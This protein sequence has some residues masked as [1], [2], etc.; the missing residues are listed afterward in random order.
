MLNINWDCCPLVAQNPL[1]R[2]FIEQLAKE[3]KS[4]S[5][6][7]NYSRDLNDFLS[8]FSNTPF[9]DQRRAR[10]GRWAGL[11]S[12]AVSGGQ[13]LRRATLRK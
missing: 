7:E 6:I 4:A 12:A 10:M 2:A 5:T 9:T 8:A 3:R 11:D 13:R 1:M